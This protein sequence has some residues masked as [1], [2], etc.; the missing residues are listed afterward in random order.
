MSIIIKLSFLFYYTFK[1]AL[2]VFAG[3]NYNLDGTILYKVLFMEAISTS[4]LRQTKNACTYDFDQK[5]HSKNSEN[6][7]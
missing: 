7:I 5:F 1:F 3:L 2:L 4:G 6:L